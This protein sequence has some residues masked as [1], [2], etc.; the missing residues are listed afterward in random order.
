[1]SAVID[2]IDTSKPAGREFAHTRP[3]QYDQ[4][5]TTFEQLIAELDPPRT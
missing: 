4:F 2:L 3:E 5:T 1:V